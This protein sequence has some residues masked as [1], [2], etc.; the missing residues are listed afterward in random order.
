MP[1]GNRRGEKL[2]PGDEIYLG[3]ACL[4]FEQYSLQVR[5]APPALLEQ[6]LHGLAHSFVTEHDGGPRGTRDHRVQQ[7]QQPVLPVEYGEFHGQGI[8]NSH[9]DAA[10]HVFLQPLP[11]GRVKRRRFQQQAARHAALAGLL[12][13]LFVQRIHR[14][15]RPGKLQILVLYFLQHAAVFRRRSAPV[16]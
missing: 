5:A 12:H 3:R 14:V 6:R 8:R 2:R 15:G 7:R 1:A 4:R 11:V 9:L 10:G 13:Q 16:R